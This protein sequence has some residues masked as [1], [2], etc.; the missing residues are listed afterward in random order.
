[1][2]AVINIWDRGNRFP[3]G[4]H[5]VLTWKKPVTTHVKFNRIHILYTIQRTP[6][7]VQISRHAKHTRDAAWSAF[8]IL[9]DAGGG[10]E[11][12]AISAMDCILI[13]W[14]AFEGCA[15]PRV[16]S[17]NELHSIIA[18]PVC[19][20]RFTGWRFPANKSNLYVR[21]ISSSLP[22]FLPSIRHFTSIT[23]RKVQW[24][25]SVASKSVWSCELWLDQS[26]WSTSRSCCH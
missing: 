6:N 10:G 24:S 11:V 3:S 13:D 2:A 20:L 23:K 17:D 12:S 25:W 15:E 26:D 19:C 1:M 21:P 8:N 4:D 16:R 7:C 5:F 9:A 18:L 14:M 22:Q